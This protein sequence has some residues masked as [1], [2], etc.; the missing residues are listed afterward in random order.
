MVNA[1]YEGLRKSGRKPGDIDIAGCA[2]FSVSDSEKAAQDTMRKIIAY[3][4]PYLEEEA[5][6]TIE[7]SGKDFDQ[8][9]ALIFEG[10]YA[11]AESIVTERMLG[12]AVVGTPK[13]VI[14]RIER[15]FEAGITQVNIGGPLGPDP[16]KTIELL[17]DHVIPYFR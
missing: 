1:I 8:I 11:E 3:F 4:G 5:L 13:Q 14:P 6:N 17:G 15:L 16:R 2:W 9:K 10:H 7:L 12:L